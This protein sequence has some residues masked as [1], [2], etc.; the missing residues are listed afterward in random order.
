MATETEKRIAETARRCRKY[1]T[2]LPWSPEIEKRVAE[3]KREE[4]RKKEGLR[5]LERKKTEDAAQH[6][7]RRLLNDS[8]QDGDA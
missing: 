7:N 3:E 5:T 1:A 4:K 8:D 2:S 6:T